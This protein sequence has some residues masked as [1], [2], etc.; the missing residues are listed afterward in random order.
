MQELDVVLRKIKNKAEG[1]DEIPTK[2]GK[3]NIQV[4]KRAASSLSQEGW[5]RKNFVFYFGA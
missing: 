5:S 3:H 2:H 4:D 1:F